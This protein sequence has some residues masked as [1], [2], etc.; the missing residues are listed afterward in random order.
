MEEK[1]NPVESLTA[2]VLD[3]H[4]LTGPRP[5]QCLCGYGDEHL[6]VRYLG[7]RHSV[8]VVDMLRGAGVLKGDA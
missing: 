3:Q 5:G 4:L 8:H 1:L 2:D 7:R 6:P